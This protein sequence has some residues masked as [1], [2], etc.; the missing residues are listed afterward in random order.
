LRARRVP[1]QGSPQVP[2]LEPRKLPRQ[3][4]ARVTFDALVEACAQLLARDGYAALTTN[5][6]A[7]RAGVSVGTL[8]QF[9]PNRDAVIAELIRQRLLAT[10]PA[11]RES[12]QVARGADDA[13]A[14]L[15]RRLVG[16]VVDDR[17]VLRALVRD[18][19]FFWDLPETRETLAGVFA[20]AEAALRATRLPAARPEASWLVVRMVYHAALEIALA[21]ADGAAH[22]AR[23]DELVELTRR[24][25][26][27]A[28]AATPGSA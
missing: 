15:V 17:E 19:P 25:L 24:M 7:E 16:R 6:I 4:R 5:A 26:G 1:A 12:M 28:D 10:L 20:A 21:D 18:V 2:D 3:D 23:I 14:W 9:F 8:Y 11:V 13:L 27:G 22:N